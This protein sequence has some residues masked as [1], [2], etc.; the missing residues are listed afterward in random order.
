MEYVEGANLKLLLARNDTVLQE[1]VGNILIDMA[2]GLE[3]IHDS[4]FMH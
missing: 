3:H 4:G 2:V 1:F